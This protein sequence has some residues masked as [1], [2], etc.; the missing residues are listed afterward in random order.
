MLLRFPPWINLGTDP[1]A[2]L[3]EHLTHNQAVS[4]SIPDG[5]THLRLGYLKAITNMTHPKKHK[6]NN[7]STGSQKNEPVTGNS[8]TGAPGDALASD[9]GAP[10]DLPENAA[11]GAVGD[12]ATGAPGDFTGNSEAGATGAPG[13]AADG[14][15]GDLTGDL[16]QNSFDFCHEQFV[17]EN[18]KI[19]RVD[20]QDEDAFIQLKNES[21]IMYT[22][23][24]GKKMELGE[25]PVPFTSD[26][27]KATWVVVS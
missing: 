4:G 19:R 1:I 13:D 2:Q 16:K 27:K 10:G 14:A 20:W 18:A 11:T 22:V 3:V 9:H 23:V 8:A 17:E 7:H 25:Y 24:D 15:A 6:N 21:A 26:D 5:A 12:A